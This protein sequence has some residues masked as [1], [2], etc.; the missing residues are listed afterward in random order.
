MLAR[1][2]I[3][4]PLIANKLKFVYGLFIRKISSSVSLFH[5]LFTI[6]MKLHIDVVHGE[7]NFFNEGIDELGLFIDK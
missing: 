6:V 1:K 2:V 3:H 7:S 4:Q 5:F